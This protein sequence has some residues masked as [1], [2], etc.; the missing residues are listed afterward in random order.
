MH[1]P[2]RLAIVGQLV[3]FA[4]PHY[5]LPVNPELGEPGYPDCYQPGHCRPPAGSKT[6]GWECQ[7][8]EGAPWLDARATLRCGQ[9]PKDLP[10]QLSVGC[11]GDSITAG[12][13]LPANN[14]LSV[15]K[16]AS[17]PSQLQVLLG[18]GYKVTNLGACG[19]DMIRNVS[20]RTASSA[21]SPFWQRPQ[22]QALVAAK[23]DILII[24]LGTNDA[25]VHDEPPCWELDCPFAQSFR[26]MIELARTL[27]TTAAGPRIYLG[28]PPPLAAAFYFGMNETV[29]NTVF[30]QLLPRINVANGLPYPVIDFYAAL[31]GTADW[32]ASFRPKGCGTLSF[33]G[34][35]VH[36][37]KSIPGCQYLL[38]RMILC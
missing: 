19:S 21:F 33:G 35:P 37:W 7:Q 5:N 20:N 26:E 3:S 25:N 36:D 38:R 31:G 10:A 23:W 27:G 28:V 17:Y 14:S 18:D 12:A 16:N 4:T 13:N 2:L 32:N 1:V 15:N 22:Y 9:R 6:G 30:P 11:I 29:I 24:T 34:P 8:T